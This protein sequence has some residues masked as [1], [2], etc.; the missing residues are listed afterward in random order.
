MSVSTHG[1]IKP[2]HWTE[3]VTRSIRHAH[4]FGWRPGMTPASS[5]ERPFYFLVVYGA[6]SVAPVW[7]VCAE[8]TLEYC[9]LDVMQP[10]RGL[11]TSASG[12]ST[13]HHSHALNMLHHGTERQGVGSSIYAN[14]GMGTELCLTG[15]HGKIRH[16]TTKS[17]ISFQAWALSSHGAVSQN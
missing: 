2:Y 12:S 15:I 8:R 14:G 4:S 6:Y 16:M 5:R 7:L 17:L 1:H 13:F 9:C 10:H 3:Q 11:L